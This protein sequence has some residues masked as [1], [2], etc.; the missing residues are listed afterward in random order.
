[1]HIDWLTVAA[2][3]ANFLVL[4]FLL[5]RFLYGP[6]TAAMARREQRI[7][8]RLAEAAARDETASQK[9]A[10]YARKLET[11]E[12]ERA[13][14]VAEAEEAADRVH[15]ERLEA[16]RA[17]IEATEERWRADLA[18]EQR[19]F[20]GE[21]RRELATTAQAIARRV[22]A[23]LADA[24]LEEHMVRMLL[25]R[26]DGLEPAVRG[27]LAHSEAITIATSR[28][29]QPARRA[30]V[31]EALHASLGA[32]TPVTYR[33]SAD[34]VCGIEVLAGGQ[35]IAWSVADYVEPLAARIHDRLA[36]AAAEAHA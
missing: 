28:E 5:K 13:R 19:E 26:L 9:A 35:R 36:S 22:L 24:D 25:S 30:K 17:E 29:L 27:A 6:V 8:D 7:A 31:T 23:D 16:A 3:I 11:F 18:R 33:Q 2:Q 32:K 34:L 10:E 12:H 20:A 15:R 1:M 4:V 14:R 21:L